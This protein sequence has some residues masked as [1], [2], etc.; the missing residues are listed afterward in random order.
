MNKLQNNNNCTCTKNN[1]VE[2]DN[3]TVKTK[4]VKNE[5]DKKTKKNYEIENSC[6]DETIAK[7]IDSIA[8]V[9]MKKYLKTGQFKLQDL[10]I[11]RV[12]A[13]ITS[14]D[15]SG[16]YDLKSGTDNDYRDKNGNTVR[17]ADGTIITLKY[18]HEGKEYTCKIKSDKI[19]KKGKPKSYIEKAPNLNS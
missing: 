4:K 9:V 1:Y 15:I 6:P 14:V 17:V 8:Q 13:K 7:E 19:P 12:D 5:S 11:E 3:I 2:E 16:K 10:P 18:N